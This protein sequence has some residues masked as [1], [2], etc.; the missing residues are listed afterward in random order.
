M[1]SLPFELV[2]WSRFI[3]SL[4]A[5]FRLSSIPTVPVEEKF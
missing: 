2:R 4:T 3:F 5:G 1:T